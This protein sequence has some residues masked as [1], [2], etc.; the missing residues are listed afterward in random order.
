MALVSALLSA[1]NVSRFCLKRPD[2]EH[3]SDDEHHD[4]RL[5]PQFCLTWHFITWSTKK[6]GRGLTKLG[7]FCIS[8][9]TNMPRSKRHGGDDLISNAVCRHICDR[10]DCRKSY[11]HKEKGTYKSKH[12]NIRYPCTYDTCMKTFIS[13]N[14]RDGHISS[15]HLKLKLPCTVPGCI[16]AYTQKVHSQHTLILYI[17]NLDFKCFIVRQTY[18]QSCHLGT[19]VKNFHENNKA[20]I[21]CDALDCKFSGASNW[22]HIMIQYICSCCHTHVQSW[23]HL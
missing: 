12:D 17:I 6:S 19:H 23:L 5:C 11:K 3:H 15:V 9:W 10:G 18:T 7:F 22:K 21:Y 14:S 1:M 2:D 16:A 20:L 4:Q 8:S 13:P